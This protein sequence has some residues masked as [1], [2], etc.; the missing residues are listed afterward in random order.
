MM[1]GGGAWGIGSSPHPATCLSGGRRSRSIAD[2][3]QPMA[4]GEPATVRISV[5]TRDD[6]ED[7]LPLVRGYCDF[8]DV[9]PSDDALLALSEAL[10]RDPEREGMQLIARDAGGRAVGFATLYWT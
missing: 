2:R 3:L 1:D 9:S 5:A 8:Y 4:N 7:L 6:F 10:V